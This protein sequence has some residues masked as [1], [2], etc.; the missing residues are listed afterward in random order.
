MSKVSST[1]PAKEAVEIS[2][3]ICAVSLSSARVQCPRGTGGFAPA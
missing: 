3:L 2:K 1:S